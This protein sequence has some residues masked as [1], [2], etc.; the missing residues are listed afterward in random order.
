MQAAAAAESIDNGCGMR[1]GEGKHK[2]HRSADIQSH[3]LTCYQLQR[4]VF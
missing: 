2:D 1:A 3:K 4:G